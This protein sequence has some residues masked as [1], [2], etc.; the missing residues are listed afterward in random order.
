MAALEVDGS[1]SRPDSEY[2][3]SGARFSREDTK[4]GLVRVQMSIVSDMWR[5][6][7]KRTGQART[8]LHGRLTRSPTGPD[9]DVPAGR[10]SAAGA[11]DSYY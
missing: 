6:A 4:A 8:L 2:P 7:C 3:S 9:L 5:I 1:T 10:K 11:D